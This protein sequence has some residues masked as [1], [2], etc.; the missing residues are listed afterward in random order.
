MKQQGLGITKS[1]R[2]E[3]QREMRRK[4]NQE[5]NQLKQFGE[6]EGCLKQ[7]DRL[8]AIDKLFK[9]SNNQT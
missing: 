1:Q 3:N 5:K 2:D 8:K 6:I 7:I 9:E 4:I